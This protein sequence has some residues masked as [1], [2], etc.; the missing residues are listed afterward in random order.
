MEDLIEEARP[1]R[2]WLGSAVT[3]TFG[4]RAKQCS[5]C[6]D[7]PEKQRLI[8]KKKVSIFPKIQSNISGLRSAATW[9]TESVCRNFSQFMEGPRKQA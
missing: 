9:H 4:D 1:E 6:E 8:K 2:L 3:C 7:Y 5:Q